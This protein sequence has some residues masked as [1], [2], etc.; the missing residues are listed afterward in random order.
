V[1]CVI[2]GKEFISIQWAKGH[3]NTKMFSKKVIF[4]HSH[5][6]NWT[7]ELAIFASKH[8]IRFYFYVKI[9]VAMSDLRYL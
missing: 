1:K 9:N 5:F 2:C 6:K 4:V 8:K 7:A 3:H